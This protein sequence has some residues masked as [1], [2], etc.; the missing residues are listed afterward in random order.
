MTLTY[1]FIVIGAGPAGITLANRLARSNKLP[2]V[3]LVEAGGKNDSQSIRVDAERWLHRTNPGHNWNYKSAPIDGFDGRV[4]DFD[5]GKGLGGSTS[6]NFGLWTVGPKDDYTE[7]AQLT[8]DEDWNWS[9]SQ[10]RF[11]RLETY[12]GAPTDAFEMY[13][14]YL[15]PNPK[16]H[17]NSGPIQTGFPKHWEPSAAALIDTWVD[18]GTKLNPDHNSGD[19]L[20]V[21]ACCSAA[22]KGF[23]SMAADVLIGAPDNLHVLTDAEV[24]CLSFD[25]TKATG[26]TTSI[27]KTLYASKEII[28]SAGSLDT[29]RILMHSGIGPADQLNKFNI[30]ILKANENVGQHMKDHFFIMLTYDRADHTSERQKFYKSKE[31]QAAAK[32]QWEKDGTGP[33]AE[34]ACA[35]GLGYEKLEGLYDT[36]E[37]QILPPS[38]QYY[39]KKPTVPHY[40]FLLN[41]AH[42]P[43]FLDPNSSPAGTSVYIFVLNQQSTG[44]TVLQSS[45]PKV[46]LIYDGNYFS[47]PYDKR[48]AIEATRRALQVINSPQFSKDTVAVQSAP[49]SE[50]EEDILEFWK[51]NT[52]SS[53]HMSG[54]AR[55]GKDDSE[56]AVNKDLKVYGVQNLRIADMSV[57][58]R[59]VK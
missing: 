54:T 9:N 8:D 13:K 50:S 43:H 26:I 27:S 34:Y 5:R 55:I 18:N 46:P 39:L 16:N 44:S 11:K 58:P 15:N 14:K 22:Y 57:V 31:L 48:I 29:P 53:W 2:S 33:L 47:H 4:L 1:D 10:E 59:I 49:K 25:G 40:E 51:K 3:L 20:G 23:R 41:A 42:I 6:I 30:P 19:P 37:F 17:G 7:L 38:E 21:A 36:P 56:G 12:H 32:A 24:L 28:L 45:D 35:M 52:L